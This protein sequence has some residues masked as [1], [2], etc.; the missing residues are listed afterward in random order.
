MSRLI[1][2]DRVKRQYTGQYYFMYKFEE[3]DKTLQLGTYSQLFH[4]EIRKPLKISLNP[5][6]IHICEFQEGTSFLFKYTAL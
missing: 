5:L 6:S 3:A 1:L 2:G 4:I